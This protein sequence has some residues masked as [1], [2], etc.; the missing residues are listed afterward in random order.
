M[1]TSVLRAARL[2]GRGGLL[3]Y[4]ALFNWTTPPMFLGTLL[5]GPLLQL[6]FYV[7]LGRQLGVA[8]DGFYVLGNAVLAASVAGIYGGTMAVSNERRYGTL[9]AVLLSPRGRGILWAGRLLPYIGNGLLVAAVTLAAGALLTGLELPVRSLW[10]IAVALL[11]AAAGCAC[12]GLLLGAVGLRL[13][14]VFVVSNLAAT[15]L[16]LVSGAEVPRSALPAVLRGAG[17]VL[18]MTHAIGAARALAAGAAVGGVGGVGRDLVA[19]GALAGCYA[20]L[21]VVLLRWFERGSRRSA[22]LDVV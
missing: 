10:G 2:A 15:V 16:L 3:A 12:F 8:D 6:L 11:G 22:T 9:G 19:E 18:P 21:A 1:T 5:A 4:R 17:A 7:N 13:R 14:D 20:L